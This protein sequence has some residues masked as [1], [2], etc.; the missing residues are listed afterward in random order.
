M[1]R[2]LIGINVKGRQSTIAKKFCRVTHA[3]KLEMERMLRDI[4]IENQNLT[5]KYN[6]TI[7]ACDI[8]TSTGRAI[9]EDKILL[10]NVNEAFN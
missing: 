3:L 10:T 1:T 9:H 4:S 7:I 8:C 5:N 6:E 2:S